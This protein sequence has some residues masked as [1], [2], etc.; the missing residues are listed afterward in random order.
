MLAWA[1]LSARAGGA[2]W[3]RPAGNIEW[4]ASEPERARLSARVRRLAAWGYPARLIG[5]AEAAELE[6]ALRLP[7]PA[8]RSP[9]FPVRVTCSPRNWS[10]GWS[11]RR[12]ATAPGCS[13]ATRAR[14]GQLRHGRRRGTGGADRRRRGDTGRRGGVLRRALGA[15]AGRAGGRNG[16]DTARAVGDARRGRARAGGAGRAGDPGWPAAAGARAGR[17]PAAP[18]GRAGPPGSAGRSRGPA[19]TRDAAAALGRGAAAAGAPRGRRA[20]GRQRHGLPGM[21]AARCRPTAGPWSAGSR[22][23]ADCTS[24]SRT[25][26]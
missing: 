24:R 3:Y 12:P 13:P 15:R 25:A 19:H 6:P 22:V 11:G 4:A 8:P 1:E 16:P 14:S 9:G 17:L 20:G 26:A 2:A 23:S 21:R 7:R 5:A 10:A 18:S